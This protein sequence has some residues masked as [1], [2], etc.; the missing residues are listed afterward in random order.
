M[1]D[2]TPDLFTMPEEFVTEHVVRDF[3]TNAFASRLHAESLVLEFKIDNTDKQAAT[4][5]AALANTDGGLVIVGIKDDDLDPIVGIKRGD[6]DKITQQLRSLIPGAM[7]EV[8]PVALSGSTDRLVLVL[9][10]DADRV[11]RPV[12]LNG[13]VWVRSPGMSTGARRDEILSLFNTAQTTH[14]TGASGVPLD[15]GRFTGFGEDPEPGTLRI[16]AQWLLPRHVMSRRYL[17]TA[18]VDA[19]ID[20]LTEGPVPNHICSNQVRQQEMGGVAWERT[21]SSAL[22]MTLRCEPNRRKV[23]YFA[24]FDAMAH[25]SL[26]GRLLDTLVGTVAVPEDGDIPLAIEDLRDQ[27]LATSHAAVAVGLAVASEIGAAYPVASPRL[28]A[29]MKGPLV[30]LLQMPRQWGATG[31][32]RSEVRF[33]PLIPGDVSVPGL[34]VM[35]REWLVPLLLNLGATRFEED[36]QRLELP[37]WV[38]RLALH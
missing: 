26:D 9:R 37:V 23:P 34:D 30:P 17:G 15:P 22:R 36:L 5:V 29:W 6:V 24:R 12:V 19:A 7:P 35:V 18:V 31:A 38:R 32:D 21:E 33:D 16:H 10:V 13:K 3:V 11:D 25:V 2:A 28:D 4:A 14:A 1:A 20:A 8:I 27:L